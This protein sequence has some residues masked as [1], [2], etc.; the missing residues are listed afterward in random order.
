VR[1]SRRSLA[2]Q[3]HLCRH[4][5]IRPQTPSTRT[6]RGAEISEPVPALS[7]IDGRHRRAIVRPQGLG[8][9]RLQVRSCSLSAR[10]PPHSA[11]KPLFSSARHV[12]QRGS[13]RDWLRH[14][15][16]RH[17]GQEFRQVRSV[18]PWLVPRTRPIPENLS[19]DD[20]R[21]REVRQDDTTD[22]LTW[23]SPGDTTSSTFATL[24]PG[25][26]IGPHADRRRRP[27]QSA[28]VAKARRRR[29]V[30]VPGDRRV[31]QSGRLHTDLSQGFVEVDSIFRA[32]KPI[33][34]VRA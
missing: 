16:S 23:A 33:I 14:G 17:T 32:E 12:G 7:D 20:A 15:R 24:K 19:P 28:A 21:E 22:R 2:G 5:T 26:L 27:R 11:R 29:E 3:E 30:A 34:C 25:D 9:V 18:G 13:V 6:A 8:Q 1:C 10:R 4:Q 31:A